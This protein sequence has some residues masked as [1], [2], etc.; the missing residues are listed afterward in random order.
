MARFSITLSEH[1]HEL[2]MKYIS[3]RNGIK[4]HTGVNELIKLGISKYSKGGNEEKIRRVV[5][6]QIDL[7]LKP[8]TESLA[9][10][11][12]KVAIMSGRTIFL[13]VQFVIDM[14]VIDEYNIAKVK[15]LHK[16]ALDLAKSNMTVNSRK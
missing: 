12:S 5:K 4:E 16:T 2:L 15:E 10:L 3:E 7:T 1:E 8:Y 14:F 9:S 6:E 13:L 11:S